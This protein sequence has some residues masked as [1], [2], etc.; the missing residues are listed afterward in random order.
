[1]Y[2]LC[3]IDQDTWTHLITNSE[4][5]YQHFENKGVSNNRQDLDGLIFKVDLPPG[6][7]PANSLTVRYSFGSYH[8]WVYDDAESKYYRNEDSIE[9]EQGQEVF[10]P[11]IDRQ[12]NHPISAD[13]VVVLF[14]NHQYFSVQPEMI[15]I[16]FDGYGKAYV[17][18]E[19]RAYLVNWGRLVNSE[20]L[21]L[22]Y[23]DG[24]RFPLKPGNIW[25]DVV[26]ANS[27]I[28]SENP[29]WMFRFLI[30]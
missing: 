21:F 13:N 25:F 27:Q 3:R 18:R 19:G 4:A 29:D 26:G 1:L 30:P 16:P 5:I 24:S 15:E 23:D 6:G 14:A 28:L 22:S 12:N 7:L 8:K 11:S 10:Q 2:P 9:A 17:F 20:I